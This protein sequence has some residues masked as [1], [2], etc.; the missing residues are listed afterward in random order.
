M[1]EVTTAKNILEQTSRK[2]TGLGVPMEAESINL[3]VGEFRNIDP[4]SLSFAFDS[5]KSEFAGCAQCQLQLT[6][7]PLLAECAAQSHHR[8]HPEAVQA[9]ACPLCGAGIGSVI[10]GQELEIVGITARS[11]RSN[12]HASVS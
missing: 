10:T 3:L 8:Y 1:H 9:F 2:I 5:L 11:S 6:V 4:E 12:K 7:S